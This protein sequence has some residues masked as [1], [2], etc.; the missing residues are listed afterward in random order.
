MPK[1]SPGPWFWCLEDEGGE[2]PMKTLAPGVLII[3]D[4]GGGIWGD[5]IDRANA[6]LISAAPDLY[7]ALETILDDACSYICPSTG[8]EGTP[9][10]HSDRCNAAR[11]ALAKARGEA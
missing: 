9:I 7:A 6:H 4:D 5:E 3:D 8:R 2:H 11:A 1:W 10:P